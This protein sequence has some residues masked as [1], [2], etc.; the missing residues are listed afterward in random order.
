[1]KKLIKKLRRRDKNP[2]PTR[3]T[4]ETIEKHREHILAGGRRFKYPIQYARHRLVF[5]AI[6][7]SLAA[8]IIAIVIGWWQLYPAQNTS[9]FMYRITKVLPVP[10]AIVDGQ[11]AL[12][13]DYLMAYRSSVYFAEQ[14]QQ[15][16]FKTDDGK[17]QIEYYK[18]QS[19]KE[20]LA[21]AYAKKL[22]KN[23]GISVSASELDSSLKDQRQSVNGEI[24]Q[25]T[26]DASILDILG[27]TPSEYRH[28]ISN[29]LLR[30]KV[31]YA[32]DNNALKASNTV[33]SS[34]TVDPKIDFK[35]LADTSSKLTNTKNTYGASGWVPKTNQDG[36]LAIAASKLKKSDVSPIIKSA[37]GDGYYIIR[38]LD[39][40]DN[41]V[42]YEFI[43]IPLTT[44]SSNLEKLIKDGK[45]TEFISIPKAT[46]G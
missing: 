27:L 19:M 46:N 45:V 18:Q 37:R 10:V 24:T 39:I 8:I 25:Q 33:Y 40:N 42:S 14:K 44:F 29:G 6:I 26:F 17:R 35:T 9:E 5:N 4:S 34:V 1:M 41:Q 22:S 12:Y 38:L 3:I 36:G 21:D 16:N 30:Q 15:L 2:P 32:V 11:P 31:S 13:S 28:K 20:A 23:L 7:I 43:N